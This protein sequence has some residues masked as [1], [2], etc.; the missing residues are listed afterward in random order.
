MVVTHVGALFYP[1]ANRFLDAGI[2]W[3]ATVCFT[4][5]LFCSAAVYA[6]KLRRG[7][8]D[9][10]RTLRRVGILFAGFYLSAL[11]VKLLWAGGFHGVEDIVKFLFFIDIPEYTEFLIAFP[12][13]A[14]LLLA[15]QAYFKRLLKIWPVLILLSIGVYAFSRLLYGF[16]WG[17]GYLDV[18]KGLLVGNSDWHRFG[19]LSYFP[20][21]AVGLTYGYYRVYLE[22]VK[23]R[24]AIV[25]AVSC[26]ALSLI[27]VL[28]TH[29]AG[30]TWNRWPPS[31]SFLLIGL[32]YTS[33]ILAL[34]DFLKRAPFVIRCCDTLELAPGRFIR[35]N[36][37]LG[38][39]IQSFYIYHLIIVF[40]ALYVMG[41]SVRS[42][43]AVWGLIL[44]LTIITAALTYFIQKIYKN[45]L[46][47]S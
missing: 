38:R 40:A 27:Y 39:S 22:S 5:F 30:D 2:W 44:A 3:G 14:L 41:S 15:M 26:A 35:M 6:D 1:G 4:V 12:L 31:V 21:Y 7:N 32:I 47:S 28:A 11:V 17:G 13:Y 9:V 46:K 43:L 37:F 23:N 8:L 10:G 29:V 19:L 24:R 16:D 42:E 20:V 36:A 25:M 18:V 45:L 33:A 34:W